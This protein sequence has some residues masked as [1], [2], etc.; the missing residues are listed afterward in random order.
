MCLC[1]RLQRLLD[2]QMLQSLPVLHAVQSQTA[3]QSV[4][5]LH[6]LTARQADRLTTKRLPGVCFGWIAVVWHST[7]AQAPEAHQ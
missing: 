4:L 7:L 3:M 1:C 6:Q 2:W 5:S